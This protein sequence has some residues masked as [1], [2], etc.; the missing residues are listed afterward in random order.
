[1]GELPQQMEANLATLERLHQQLRLNADNQTR[2][3]ER[4]QTMSS[5]LAEADSLLASTPAPVAPVAPVAPGRPTGG[6][7]SPE[8][9]LTRLK[10]ELAKLRGQFNDKYPDVILLAREVATL[11]REVDDAKAREPKE[12][13]KEQPAG[14]QAAPPGR[15]PV[16]PYVLRLKEALSEAEADIK[17]FKGE[18]RRLKEAIASY[19]ARIENVPRREQEFREL[20]RDYDSTREL[21]Q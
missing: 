2:A 21:Y 16:T 19:Q 3:S 4:R 1:M 8:A 6:P 5:Q 7:D 10:Q 15:Q 20:A 12:N 17:V 9:R 13:E 11:E 14:A 18:E